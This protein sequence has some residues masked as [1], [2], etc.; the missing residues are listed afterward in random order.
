MKISKRGLEI[1]TFESFINF[2]NLKKNISRP[3]FEIFLEM[4]YFNYNLPIIRK[5]VS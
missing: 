5:N 3:L 2:M 4:L 1:F